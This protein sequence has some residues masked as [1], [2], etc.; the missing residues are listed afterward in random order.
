M[1]KLRLGQK[2]KTIDYVDGSSIIEEIIKL[3]PL[4]ART[5]R[6]HALWC[7]YG[8]INI[9]NSVD[10]FLNSSSNMVTNRYFDFKDY[11]E[12]VRMR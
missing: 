10:A 1:Q 4:T 6:G 11:Y 3:K 12:A 9:Y 8:D 5:I 7:K 2:F